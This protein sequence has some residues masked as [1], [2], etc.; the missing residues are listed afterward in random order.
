MSNTQTLQF[1]ELDDESRAYLAKVNSEKGHGMPG[2]YVPIANNLPTVGCV[3]GGI[4]LIL[5]LVATVT[6]IEE[7]PLAI[8]MLQTAGFLL[9]GWLVIYA[10]R[11]WMAGSG[12]KFA[13][14]ATSAPAMDAEPICTVPFE[15]RSDQGE[16]DGDTPEGV[17]STGMGW[18]MPDAA[19]PDHG[20]FDIN[21]NAAMT[22]DGP[23]DPMSGSVDT[24]GLR[25]RIV[26]AI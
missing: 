4:I 2:V 17:V 1:E 11:V 26:Q 5:T 8:A 7:E 18:W 25:C 6:L 10:F 12:S 13:G 21:I 19:G 15:L 24:R 22:Y 14:P 20:A 16:T 9:G 3:F 23:W